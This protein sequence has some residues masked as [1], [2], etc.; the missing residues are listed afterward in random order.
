M[1]SW[2]SFDT[3]TLIFLEIAAET[4]TGLMFAFFAAQR[5]G[6]RIF[7]VDSNSGSLTSFVL[8]NLNPSS[9]ARKNREYNLYK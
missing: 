8:S 9:F 1:E 6:S 7:S 5:K 4:G 2:C 3:L